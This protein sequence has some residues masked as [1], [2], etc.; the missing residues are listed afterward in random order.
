MVIDS[1]FQLLSTWKLLDRLELHKNVELASRHF[2]IH[3]SPGWSEIVMQMQRPHIRP[4]G[5]SITARHAM[6]FTKH[7]REMRCTSTELQ[8]P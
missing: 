6:H 3:C 2:E 4:I 8:A 7:Q 5:S 1:S